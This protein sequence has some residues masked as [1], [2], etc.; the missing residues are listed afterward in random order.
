MRIMPNDERNLVLAQLLRDLAF[1]VGASLAPKGFF[2]HLVRRLFAGPINAMAVLS[3]FLTIV[4]GILSPCLQCSAGVFGY[5]VKFTSLHLARKDLVVYVV[6]AAYERSIVVN[7][8]SPTGQKETSPIHAGQ[9]RDVTN[10]S[11]AA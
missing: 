5:F 2:D 8:A 1:S 9:T 11:A 3:D 10:G 4:A 7:E 6:N